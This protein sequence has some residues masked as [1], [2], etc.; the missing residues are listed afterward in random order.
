MQSKLDTELT[1][2]KSQLVKKTTV[3]SL[4]VLMRLSVIILKYT[5][6]N[7]Y[8]HNN[9]QCIIML[10]LLKYNEL[11]TKFAYTYID[12]CNSVLLYGKIWE[13]AKFFESRSMMQDNLRSYRFYW[14]LQYVLDYHVGIMNK[15]SWKCINNFEV[16]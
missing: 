16:S 12:F 8:L 9:S 3:K 15:V 4:V 13:S 7:E 2:L 11:I 14:N 10:N 5:L 6:T 1:D